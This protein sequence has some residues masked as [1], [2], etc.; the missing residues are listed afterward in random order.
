V[1]A[2]GECSPVKTIDSVVIRT[3]NSYDDGYR[4]KILT[5]PRTAE[6]LAHGGKDTYNTWVMGPSNDTR[7][8]LEN[9]QVIKRVRTAP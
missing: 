4:Q 1:K 8:C 9:G 7:Q 6:N 2:A 5:K 3:Q